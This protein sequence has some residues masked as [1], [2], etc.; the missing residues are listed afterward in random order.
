MV[1]KKEA[2][3]QEKEEVNQ[4]GKD[5]EKEEANLKGKDQEKEDPAARMQERGNL[6]DEN[7]E[8]RWKP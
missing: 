6:T 5:Q 7:V 3:H 1:R 2:N 8:T 4:K